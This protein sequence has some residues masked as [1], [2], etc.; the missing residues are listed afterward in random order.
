MKDIV[1]RFIE[2]I[3]DNFFPLIV[4]L[5]IAICCLT[6]CGSKSIVAEPT[7]IVEVSK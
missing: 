7:P 4:C 5:T 1:I 2:L 6:K 3:D